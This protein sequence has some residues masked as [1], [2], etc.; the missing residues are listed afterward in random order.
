MANASVVLAEPYT[1]HG[2]HH[3][4]CAQLLVGLSLTSLVNW[5]Q[6]FNECYAHECYYHRFCSASRSASSVRD[7][8][9]VKSSSSHCPSIGTL[10]QDCKMRGWDWIS[11]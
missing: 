9:L 2:F 10:S 4:G 3:L 5:W 7:T 1:L 8:F 11:P 6:Q